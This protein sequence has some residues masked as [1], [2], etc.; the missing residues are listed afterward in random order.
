MDTNPSS[1]VQKIIKIY[2]TYIDFFKSFKTSKRTL[3]FIIPPDSKSN[4]GIIPESKRNQTKKTLKHILVSKITS[5]KRR[6]NI[7]YF[8]GKGKSNLTFLTFLSQLI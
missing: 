6:S 5:Q 3:T 2:F 8:Q 7:N 1:W 4:L